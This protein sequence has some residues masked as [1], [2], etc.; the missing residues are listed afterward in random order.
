ME[1][2]MPGTIHSHATQCGYDR[3][4]LRSGLHTSGGFGDNRGLV[5]V[6][7]NEVDYGRRVL[8]VKR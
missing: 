7:P 1:A 5:F 3:D 6:W 4:L 2:S 8:V